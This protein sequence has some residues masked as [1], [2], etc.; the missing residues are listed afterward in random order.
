M[1]A[2]RE[3]IDGLVFPIFAVTSVEFFFFSLCER[4]GVR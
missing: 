2:R 4:E 3:A 1:A